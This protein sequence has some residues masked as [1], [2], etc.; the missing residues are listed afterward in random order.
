VPVEVNISNLA[1]GPHS[2]YNEFNVVSPPSYFSFPDSIA[3]PVKQTE[4]EFENQLEKLK[5]IYT[6]LIM[7]LI[8]L[9]GLGIQSTR[10]RCRNSCS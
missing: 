5:V 9:L 2:E 6:C 1:L 4:K 8:D 10:N 7:K 3:M